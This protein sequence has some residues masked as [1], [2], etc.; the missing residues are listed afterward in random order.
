MLRTKLAQTTVTGTL[1]QLDD[2][3]A[4]IDNFYRSNTW[5][6]EISYTSGDLKPGEVGSVHLTAYEANEGDL[7]LLQLS[8]DLQ[9]LFLAFDAAARDYGWQSDQGSSGD[10]KKSESVYLATRNE[11]LLEL[12]ESFA[13]LVAAR[14]QASQS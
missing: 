2:L 8:P 11:F 4:R 3:V 7:A 13:Q 14:V 5:M 6:V 12:R 10:A 1:E 9:K